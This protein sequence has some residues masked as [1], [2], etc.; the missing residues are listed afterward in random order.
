M[1]LNRLLLIMPWDGMVGSTLLAKQFYGV[2]RTLLALEA[3][4]S[5]Y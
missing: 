2:L 5:Y 3:N 1:G 4:F